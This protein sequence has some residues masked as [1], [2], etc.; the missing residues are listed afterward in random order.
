MLN[1]VFVMKAV[2]QSSLPT[3]WNADL[4]TVQELFVL[5]F[6]RT[7][8]WSMHGALRSL[9]WQICSI[10]V[11]IEWYVIP[12]LSTCPGLRVAVLDLPHRKPFW[13]QSTQ[14]FPDIDNIASNKYWWLKLLLN[15]KL[16]SNQ[17]IGPL[18]SGRILSHKCN[19]VHGCQTLLLEYWL[20]WGPERYLIL[21]LGP[22]SLS[23]LSLAPR[24]FTALGSQ[25]CEM[26]TE[27]KNSKLHGR[28]VCVLCEI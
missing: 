10:P 14:S 6:G 13:H 23:F 19:L 7:S 28:V 20:W 21:L 26:N 18:V 8:F 3:T 27:M 2:L 15:E 12:I 11:F 1:A 22:Y 5:E 9:T 24:T 17:F 16:A 25:F 4:N